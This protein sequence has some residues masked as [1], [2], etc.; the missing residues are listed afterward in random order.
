M[1]KYFT[2]TLL[3]FSFI[4]FSQTVIEGNVKQSRTNVSLNSVTIILKNQNDEIISFT[5]TNDEGN[6]KIL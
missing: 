1:R 2:I 5:Y 4:L 6:F 3:F